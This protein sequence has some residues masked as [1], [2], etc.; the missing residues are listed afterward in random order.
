[1][2]IFMDM[3]LSEL[4]ILRIGSHQKFQE[5]CQS[6]RITKELGKSFVFVLTDKAANSVVAVWKILFVKAMT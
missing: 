1:M 6:L 5:I 4:H 3:R 2:T